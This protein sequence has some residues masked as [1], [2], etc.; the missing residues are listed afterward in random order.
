MVRDPEWGVWVYRGRR[1][2]GALAQHGARPHSWERLV[3]GELNGEPGAVVTRGREAVPPLRPYQVPRVAEMRAAHAAGAPGFMLTYPTGSGKTATGISALTSLPGMGAVL[4]VTKLS[5]VPAWRAAIDVFARGGQRWVVVNPEGLVRL[6]AHPRVDLSRL[7]AEQAA[8]LAA[9]GGRSRVAWDGVIVDESQVL[10]DAESIRSR[11]LRRITHPAGGR[12]PWWLRM[13]ATGFSSPVETAYLADLIAHVAGVDEP[14]DLARGPYKEWLR[15]LGFALNTNAAGRWYH[16]F[17]PGDVSMVRELLYSSGVGATATPQELGL[18]AQARELLPVELTPKELEHYRLSWNEF[19]RVRGM[20]ADQDP[21]AVHEPGAGDG[22]QAAALR[23]VQRASLLKAPYVARIVADLVAEGHQ[24]AVPAW[25]LESVRAL[26]AAIARELGARGLCDR[27]AE[28]TGEEP[29]LREPRRKAFQLGACQVVVVNAVEGINLHAGE[30]DVGGPGVHATSTPR[31]TVF[32]DV[33]TG[34]KKL[35]Q[36]EGRTQRDG[37]RARAVYVVV[38]DTAETEWLAQAFRAAAGTQALA[39][40]P[41]D[42][43]DLT[44]LADELGALRAS[45]AAGAR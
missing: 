16:Q 7:P 39:Q 3:E 40:A 38:L 5:V 28:I 41:K 13:S 6:L 30:K 11:L 12:R 10:A 34:G 18:P 14:S 2:P 33:L 31:V 36:G 32:A 24:V 27:V 4:V 1:L 15:E 20:D 44:S 9:D 23:Q 35:L 42:A 21:D 37:L 8:R 43:A 25:Y 17:N 19:R 22:R 26:A 29:G 45:P